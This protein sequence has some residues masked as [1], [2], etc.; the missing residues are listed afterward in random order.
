MLR[1]LHL[2]LP[3]R[4]PCVK[5]CE[6]DGD[7]VTASF[8]RRR[9]E[10][11]SGDACLRTAL[12]IVQQQAKKYASQPHSL[13]RYCSQQRECGATAAVRAAV[14]RHDNSGTANCCRGKRTYNDRL[15]GCCSSCSGATSWWSHCLFSLR[16]W[17]RCPTDQ[18]SLRLSS[19]PTI[20][21][22]IA[23]VPRMALDNSR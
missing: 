6:I 3:F 11:P 19:H 4:S 2:E 21:Q 8:D 13:L 22:F 10:H 20:A 15:D 7:S 1:A 17:I 12:Y 16:S 9:I 23:L 14:S 5:L 18:D